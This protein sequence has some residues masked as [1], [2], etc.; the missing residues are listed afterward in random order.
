M[1]IN[2]KARAFTLAEV[3]I[4]LLIIGIIASI[5]I[6]GIIA[7]T[8][9]AELKTAW[10]KAYSDLNQ[11]TMKLVSDNGGSLK[12]LFTNG[13]TMKETF[14]PYL[15]YI[16]NCNDSSSSGNCWHVASKFFA[17]DGQPSTLTGWS[18]SYPGLV[19]SNGIL[20]IF[21]STNLNCA[22]GINTSGYSRCGEIN[23]DVN[24]FKG[25]NTLGKDIFQIHVLGNRILPR[26]I[27]GDWNVGCTNGGGD[28]G[29]GCGAVY[30][31]Q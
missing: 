5:V 16:Q 11:A 22:A 20:L 25:P 19:L 13:N 8:Q 14:K 4:T 12:G 2:T 7:D 6:P 29:L 21:G 10:K 30:L 24:G 23:V 17:L 1:C 18:N 9:Q 15:N 31:Y 26:G 3:L 28:G 27:S